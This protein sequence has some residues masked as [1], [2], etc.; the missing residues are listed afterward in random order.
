MTNEYSGWLIE[1]YFIKLFDPSS[2]SEAYYHIAQ[3]EVALYEHTWSETIAKGVESGPESLENLKPLDVNRVYQTIFGVDVKVLVYV[4]FP[5]G[6]RRWGVDKVP[7]ASS[8]NRNIGWTDNIT[9]PYDSPSFMTEFF[10]VKNGSYE[11]PFLYAY[12]PGNRTKKPKLKFIQNRLAIEPVTDEDTIA[13]LDTKTIPYRFVTLG[14]L[15]A[16]RAGR[17]S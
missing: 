9:S 12:N 8:S 14:G 10:Q 7:K 1:G 3:R 6:Q 2:L 16:S 13:K 5:Q 17:G 15:P 4:D 11:Y